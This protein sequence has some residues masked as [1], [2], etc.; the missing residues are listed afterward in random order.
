MTDIKSII[1]ESGI[2]ST[3]IENLKLVNQNDDKGSR[4]T[5]KDKPLSSS[6]TVSS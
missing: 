3:K 5:K 2:V 4:N 1:V 6:K